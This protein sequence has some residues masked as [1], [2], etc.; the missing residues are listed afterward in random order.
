LLTTCHGVIINH[1]PM[2]EALILCSNMPFIF[3][4]CSAHFRKTQLCKVFSF[5]PS[6]FFSELANKD[7]PKYFIENTR[8]KF[9]FVKTSPSGKQKIL[10]KSETLPSISYKTLAEVSNL[11]KVN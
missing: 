5:L 7:F 4:T 8:K 2:L 10:G 6:L 9:I 3:I 11:T 1:F